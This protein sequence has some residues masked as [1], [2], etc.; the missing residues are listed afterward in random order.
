MKWFVSAESYGIRTITL[1][2]VIC[3]RNFYKS[4]SKRNSFKQISDRQHLMGKVAEVQSEKRC[5]L[6]NETK[7]RIDSSDYAIILNDRM[8]NRKKINFETITSFR[9]SQ[10][11][12]LVINHKLTIS[13]ALLFSKSRLF[14][15]KCKSHWRVTALLDTTNQNGIAMKNYC[16]TVETSAPNHVQAWIFVVYD[17]SFYNRKLPEVFQSESEM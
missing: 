15:H 10:S 16:Y 7:I 14:T 3:I 11:K 6:T 17:Y 12:F 2:S 13:A 5:G 9:D 8:L 1:S 4:V